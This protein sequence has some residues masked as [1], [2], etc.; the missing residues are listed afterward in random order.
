MSE[1]LWT[2]LPKCS[3]LRSSEKLVSEMFIK[4][5]ERELTFCETS[6]WNQRQNSLSSIRWSLKE[7]NH[8]RI[9]KA[10]SREE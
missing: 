2:C 3:P 7:N 6:F 4:Y 10:N 8:V 1:E 9:S 5:L